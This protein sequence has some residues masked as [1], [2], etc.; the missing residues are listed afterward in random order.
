[1]TSERGVGSQFTLWLPCA[2]KED[3]ERNKMPSATV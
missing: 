2:E 3:H 1:V